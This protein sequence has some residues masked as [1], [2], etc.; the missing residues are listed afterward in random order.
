MAVL[1]KG[2]IPEEQEGHWFML[3]AELGGAAGR[4]RKEYEDEWE[5]LDY[6]LSKKTENE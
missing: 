6:D 5:A 4:A 1:R 3:T 2:H